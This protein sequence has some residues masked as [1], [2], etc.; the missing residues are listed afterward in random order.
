MGSCAF[1]FFHDG[2]QTGDRRGSLLKLF[3]PILSV[4][5]SILSSHFRKLKGTR[6]AFCFHLPLM[7][8]KDSPS[9]TLK[10]NRLSK[11]PPFISQNEEEACS[12]ELEK[13]I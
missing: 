4:Y 2:I 13:M 11:I 9:P 1:Q 3:S 6:D 8:D 12:V 7:D 10:F 5:G